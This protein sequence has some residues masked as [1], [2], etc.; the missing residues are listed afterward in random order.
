MNE[1][2]LNESSKIQGKSKTYMPDGGAYIDTVVAEDLENVILVYC[3]FG[4]MKNRYFD[5][6]EFYE[7]LSYEEFNSILKSQVVY[8]L[9][10]SK[11]ESEDIIA[12]LKQS[13]LFTQ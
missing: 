3:Y 8:I 7:N 13:P 5:K 12:D 4:E 1:N 2:D 9:K 6:V 11:E 10:S